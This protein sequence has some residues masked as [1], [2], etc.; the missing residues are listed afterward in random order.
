[1]RV[2]A[3]RI[4]KAAGL[5]AQNTRHVQEGWATAT[6]GHE[7]PS[8]VVTRPVFR[9][10][11][12]S[13]VIVHMQLL[14]LGEPSGISSM[15]AEGFKKAP[16]PH[17]QVWTQGLW[18]VTPVLMLWSHC[19][20]ITGWDPGVAICCHVQSGALG[21]PGWCLLRPLFVFFSS[22]MSHPLSIYKNLLCLDCGSRFQD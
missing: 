8:S 9:G 15:S 12:G 1:M 10:S 17:P 19:E 5:G 18:E 21:S 7:K 14:D 22:K 11:V 2:I 16:G 3:W 4:L 13:S 6:R 20:R